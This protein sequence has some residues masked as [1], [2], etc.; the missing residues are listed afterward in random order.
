V[1]LTFGVPVLWSQNLGDIARQDRERRS[2]LSSHAPVLTNDDLAREHI[3]TPELR[4]RILRTQAGTGA[5]VPGDAPVAP[6]AEELLPPVTVEMTQQVRSSA[7]QPLA[8]EAVQPAAVAAQTLAVRTPEYIEP[9]VAVVASVDKDEPVSVA[10][11]QVRSVAVQPPALEVIQPSLLEAEA[12]AA[13]ALSYI[14]PAIEVIQPAAVTETLVSRT[15]SYSEPAVAPTA[16]VNEPVSLGEYARRLRTYR[17][18]SVTAQPLDAGTAEPL[19]ASHQ[20][21]ISLGAFARQLRAARLEQLDLQTPEVAAA[22]TA[23]ASRDEE[24]SLGEYAR[25]LRLR[26]DAEPLAAG[27]P[28][29]GDSAADAPVSLGEYARQLRAVRA[30]PA[31]E[32]ADITPLPPRAEVKSLDAEVSLGEY[33]RELRMRRAA[34][35]YMRLLAQDDPDIAAV[36]GQPTAPLRYREI[37]PIPPAPSPRQSSARAQV[38]APKNDSQ[39]VARG[40]LVVTVRRGYSLWRLAR[41]YLGS[42]ARWRSITFARPHRG[43]PDLIYVGEVVLIPVD[44]PQR[45]YGTQLAKRFL[46]RRPR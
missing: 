21:E 6:I 9:A 43:S 32:S 11:Y 17:A 12:L 28:A 30:A 35:E 20:Q 34:E 2:R 42:G 7:V 18:A 41:T 29:A 14:E 15:P 1:G 22:E 24:I 46:G 3:L 27:A 33:A 25:Q 16:D 23:A 36:I 19:I 40:H 5:G 44:D 8:I 39:P 26:F 37:R 31:Y 4:N 38:Q 45:P 13:R 10:D